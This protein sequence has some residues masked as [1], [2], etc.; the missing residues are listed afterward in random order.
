M[1]RNFCSLLF[2]V[3][4]L[5]IVESR[6]VDIVRHPWSGNTETIKRDYY[7]SLLKLALEKSENKFGLYKIEQFNTPLNQIR[8]MHLLEHN[9][10]VDLMWTMTSIE[11]ENKLRAIRIPLVKG[12]MGCR[13]FLI[14][15]GEQVIFEDINSVEQLKSIPVGQGRNWPDTKILKHNGFNLQC[16]YKII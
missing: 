1:K 12:L 6:A 5:F 13:I 15:K 7:L 3:F 2:I 8:S 16:N 4:F 14:R 11:R 10:K 9:S